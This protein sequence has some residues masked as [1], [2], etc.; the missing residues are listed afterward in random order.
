VAAIEERVGALEMRV[1]GLETWAGPGQADAFAV[2]LRMVRA[3]LSKVRQTQD[4]HS[5]MLEVLTS[6]VT[7]LKTDVTGLKTDVAG[8]KTDVAELKTDVAE[9]K[10]DVAELKTDVAELKTDVAG[11][12]SDMTEM[13]G[14]LR[15]ILARLPAA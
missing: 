2:S 14:T 3:D 6:D 10:T 8:L 13:K 1:D 9:L 12:R 4:R 15:E 5:R 7:G 11:L